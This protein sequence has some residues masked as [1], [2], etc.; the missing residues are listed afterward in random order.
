MLP[1]GMVN[2]SGCSGAGNQSR[3]GQESLNQALMLVLP[4]H[5]NLKF[6]A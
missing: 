5:L 2:Q 6:V 4:S 1:F 3:Y